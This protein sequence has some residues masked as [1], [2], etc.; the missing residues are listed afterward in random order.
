MVVN[1]RNPV[2]FNIGFSEDI[3]SRV[4]TLLP[5][6]ELISH[7]FTS[8]IMLTALLLI[9]VILGVLIILFT[10]ISNILVIYAVL[11]YPPLKKSQNLLLIS[12]ALADISCAVLVMPVNVYWNLVG[13]WPFNSAFC[14][15]HLSS[16]S[17]LCTASVLNLVAIALDRYWA[18][19]DPIKYTY[20]RTT[21]F[22]V[23]MALFAW[24]LA[25]IIV[26]L[27][28][29]GFQFWFKWPA[30]ICDFP[31]GFI[32]YLTTG[33]FIAPLIIMSIIYF[34][35]YLA[36]KKKMR[37][38]K[39]KCVNMVFVHSSNDGKSS[40]SQETAIESTMEEISLEVSENTRQQT[41]NND[42][43]IKYPQFIKEKQKIS[44]ARERKAVKVLGIVVGVFVVCWLPF[45]VLDNIYYFW[46]QLEEQ[47]PYI[48]TNIIYWLGYVNSTCNPII[49]TIFNRDFR[50]AFKKILRIKR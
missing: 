35:I 7:Y 16:D 32:L 17:T 15:F 23:L 1:A 43:S 29:I 37:T 45:F 12:L 6:R 19:F 18:I 33:Q 40:G 27:P 31:V 30:D 3:L 36:I 26:V 42:V 8:D 50:K 21:K 14:K 47:V 38:R 13:D 2:K 4:Y 39:N 46:P 44:I 49:Y 24:I 10:T 20:R 9:G 22:I 25:I 5:V 34:M 11:T 48:I 41:I 28:A